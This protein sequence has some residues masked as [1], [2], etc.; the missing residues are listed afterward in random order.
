VPLS[1]HT[2]LVKAI[3]GL[4]PSQIKEK[5]GYIFGRNIGYIIIYQ[6]KNNRDQKRLNKT[7]QRSQNVLLVNSDIP[8][9]TNRI[10]KSW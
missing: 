3:P 8:S 2:T 10:I 6:L 4:D 5:R 9:F 7:P 1:K